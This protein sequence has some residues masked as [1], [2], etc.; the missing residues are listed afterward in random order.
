MSYFQFRQYIESGIP[1]WLPFLVPVLAFV[2][3]AWKKKKAE[4]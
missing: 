4:K 2:W 3:F 1:W